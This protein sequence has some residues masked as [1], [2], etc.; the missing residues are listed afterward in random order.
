MPKDFSFSTTSGRSMKARSFSRS[1]S[2]LAGS[3]E[4]AAS[5][6][7]TSS[8]W[9]TPQNTRRET[10]RKMRRRRWIMFVPLFDGG[11]TVPLP[12]R[13]V[14]IVSGIAPGSRSL[15]QYSRFA[16]VAQ[17]ARVDQVLPGRGGERALQGRFAALSV[18]RRD[19]AL[20]LVQRPRQAVRG[21]LG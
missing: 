13:F 5:S 17:H 14:R 6:V 16:H 21:V 11:P 20:P 7:P 3:T 12:R 9:A 2:G 10:A 4:A 19:D 15:V 18:A 1:A 8:A